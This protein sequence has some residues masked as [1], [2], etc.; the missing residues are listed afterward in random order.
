[1]TMHTAC[2]AKLQ[3]GTGIICGLFRDLVLREPLF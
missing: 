3:C 2:S 1:M